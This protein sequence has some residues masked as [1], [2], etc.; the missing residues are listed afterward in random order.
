MILVA[1]AR[2]YA[3]TP[4]VREAW[5]TLFDW[6]AR[7]SSVPLEYVD[8]AAP[9]LL[10]TLWAREDLGATFMCGFP[11][12]SAARKPGLIAA[13]V[14][15]PPRYGG[16][17]RYCT[18]FIVRADRPFARLSDTF[19]GRIGWTVGHSQSGYNAVRYHLSRYR[20]DHSEPPFAEW[21]GPLITPRRVIE[22]VITGKI[23]VGPLDS[24]VHDL[25]KRNESETAVR[26][27]TVESTAM[28]PI[29]PLVVSSTVADDIVERLRGALMSGA[30]QTELAAT[31]DVLVM[32]RFA[33]VKPTDYAVLLSQAREADRQEIAAP[34]Q[35]LS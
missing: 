6:V 25:L 4:A 13:P 29:P 21:V 3:V 17:P 7:T 14:P 28:T 10:E 32:T 27:R 1:N 12:A 24:Y 2:M 33:A 18:D 11:F 30:I 23:D 20:R 26:L 9:A 35:G 5:R 19:G 8:H 15:S 16:L 22:H 31:F 34:A